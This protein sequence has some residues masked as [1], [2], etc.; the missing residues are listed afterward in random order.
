MDISY[1]EIYVMNREE[2]R[3]QIVNNYLATENIS[4]VV[5]LWRLSRNVVRKWVRRFEQKGEKGL[6]D[7]SKKP[8]SSPEK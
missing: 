8:H 4:Q 1:R 2:A 7:E 5:R 3:K 6:G